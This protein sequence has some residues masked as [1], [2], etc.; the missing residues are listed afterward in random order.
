VY[1]RRCFCEEGVS[2]KCAEPEK[3]KH[4]HVEYFGECAQQQVL[5]DFCFAQITKN[6]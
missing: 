3:F 5:P 4:M 6:S 1:Q 2:D